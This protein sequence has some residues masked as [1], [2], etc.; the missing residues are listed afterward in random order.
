[1]P[2]EALVIDLTSDDANEDDIALVVVDARHHPIAGSKNRTTTAPPPRKLMCKKRK[3][4]LQTQQKAR[5]IRYDPEHMRSAECTQV[6]L[7]NQAAMEMYRQA[8]TCAICL[9]TLQDLTSTPCGHIFCRQ[10]LV[11][12]LEASKKCPMC[13]KPTQLHEIHALYL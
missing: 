12:A 7:D 3:L 2:P 1:M 9:D 11:H 8:T 5:H 6:C 10:C 4:A 13:Q